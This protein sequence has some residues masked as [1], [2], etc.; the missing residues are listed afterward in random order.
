M[1]LHKRHFIDQTFPPTRR[2]DWSGSDLNVPG[3]SAR[4]KGRTHSPGS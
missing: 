3:S 2:Q 1:H 4:T